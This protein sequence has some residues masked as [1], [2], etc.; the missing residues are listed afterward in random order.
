[1]KS[2][3]LLLFSVLILFCCFLIFMGYTTQVKAQ[4]VVQDAGKM[5]D[6]TDEFDISKINEEPRVPFVGTII[7]MDMLASSESDT[8]TYKQLVYD[9]VP[10]QMPEEGVVLLLRC[11]KLG[12]QITPQ[13]LSQV[14]DEFKLYNIE[15]KTYLEPVGAVTVEETSS[16]FDLLFYDE[17]DA[18]PLGYALECEGEIYL[19]DNMGQYSFST[20]PLRERTVDVSELPPMPAP[21]TVV[22]DRPPYASELEDL[23]DKAVKSRLTENDDVIPADGKTV[24]AVFS[25]QDVLN[26][27]S[28]DETDRQ[29]A[30]RMIQGLS[31][32]DQLEE[33]DFAMLIHSGTEVIGHYGMT[34]GSARRVYT[35]LTIIDLHTMEQYPTITVSVSDPPESIN[36][37]ALYASGASGKYE[38]DKA[39]AYIADKY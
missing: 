7:R 3:N 12:S 18:G 24:I 9:S 22:D 39:I 2:H 13:E 8:E 37:N 14:I 1:M 6:W 5:P 20:E 23:L 27:C 15:N 33:A 35:L 34:A 36:T 21:G 30:F 38:P 11:C 28:L 32:A 26:Q 10:F 31:F 4:D 17:K 25:E 29:D 19:F 16:D